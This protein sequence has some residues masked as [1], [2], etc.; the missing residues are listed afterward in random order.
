MFD[1]KFAVFM[2]DFRINSAHKLRHPRSDAYST[3]QVQLNKQQIWCGA[4]CVNNY[5]NRIRPYRTVSGVIG[6]HWS[7]FHSPHRTTDVTKTGLGLGL[8]LAFRDLKNS[9][10]LELT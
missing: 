7:K 5:H 8:C 4:A 9:Q 1:G 10:S 6:L 3:E 2:Y